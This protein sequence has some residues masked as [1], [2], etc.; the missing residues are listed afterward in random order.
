MPGKKGASIV[1]P[2]L[3]ER[4]KKPAM[5][6][7][8]GMKMTLASTECWR[9]QVAKEQRIKEEWRKMYAPNW[10]DDEAAIIERVKARE[11]AR[12]EK[13]QV[14][15]R[16]LLLDGV[17]KEGGGRAAYLKARLE[18]HPQSK[19]VEPLTMSQNVGWRCLEIP[20]PKSDDMTFSRKGKAAGRYKRPGGDEVLPM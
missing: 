14:P 20:P 9:A 1:D 10:T 15:E 12:K 11:A 8:M 16:A 19:E 17:S 4:E 13:A 6:I 3:L 2:Q 5:T 7:S 18:L